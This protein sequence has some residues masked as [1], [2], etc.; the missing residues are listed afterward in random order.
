[1]ENFL[2]FIPHKG[3]ISFPVGK[4]VYAKGQDDDR[5]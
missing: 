5:Q 2:L 3:T 1:M 4:Y